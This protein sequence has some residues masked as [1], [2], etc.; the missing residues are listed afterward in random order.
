[1]EPDE[2]RQI[3][4]LPLHAEDAVDDDHARGAARGAL[5]EEAR[6]TG[7]VA[8]IE[9]DD[10]PEGHPPA[11]HDARVIELVEVHAIAAA[12]ERVDDGEVALIARA[13]DERG[14]LADEAREARLEPLVQVE[15]AVQEAA[16]R[17]HRPVA[18]YR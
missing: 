16:A 3:R 4:D 5:A 2:G 11:V 9:P 18:D 14:L 6:Q 8:V 13:E 7:Q 12:D 17:A 10:I 15:V 1:R